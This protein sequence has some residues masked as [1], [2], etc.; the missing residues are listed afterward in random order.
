MGLFTYARSFSRA[1][2]RFP[3]ANKF[4]YTK[5]LMIRSIVPT[6]TTNFLIRS[7]GIHTAIASAELA[8]SLCSLEDEDESV[9]QAEITVTRVR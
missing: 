5:P 7:P 3:V 1:I 2:V 9:I 8:G 4:H 6:C